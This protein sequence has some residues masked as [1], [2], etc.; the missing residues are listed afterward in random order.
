MPDSKHLGAT[1]RAD[2]L[3]GRPLILQGDPLRILYLY[4]L[5][6]LKTVSLQVMPLLSTVSGLYYYYTQAVKT[7]RFP[8]IYQLGFSIPSLHKDLLWLPL[9][10]LGIEA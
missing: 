6:T 1:R 5:S 8:N 9:S 10:F 3:R 4:L 2:P 7:L